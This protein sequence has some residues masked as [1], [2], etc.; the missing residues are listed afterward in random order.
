[1]ATT[2]QTT[3][4]PTWHGEVK[5]YF[6]AFD[7]AKM[8]SI[9]GFDLSSYSFV[10][11]HAPDIYQRVSLPPDADGRMPM[12]PG[13]PWSQD[14]INGF[15]AWMT[16]G[17]PEGEPQHPA[18]FK[19]AKAQVT[20][21]VRKSLTELGTDE[22]AKLKAAFAGIM[23]LGTEDLN[24][25]F[26]NAAIHGLPLAFC[27]HHDPG[28]QPWHRVQMWAFENC[29][30]SIKGCEDVTLPYWDFS[31]LLP[32]WMYEAPFDSYTL[33]VDIG[34]ASGSPNPDY[35]KG[36]QTTRNSAQVILDNFNNDVLK[37]YAN[38]QSEKWWDNFNGLLDGTPNLD[39]IQGHDAGHDATGD[40]M[41][42][43][44]ISAFDP[45][46]WFYHCN[47]DRM[48][49][50]WQA[51]NDAQTVDGFMKTIKNKSSSSYLVFTNPAVGTMNPWAQTL[52]RADLTAEFTIDL[53]TNFDVSYNSMTLALPQPLANKHLSLG[54][55]RTFAADD[56]E[57]DVRVADLNR[58][59]IPGTF[60]VHLLKDGE[61]LGT[62]VFFQPDEV[63]K[64][65][66]CMQ[67][68]TVHFDFRLPLAAVKGGELSI[69]VE[70]KKKEMY[71]DTVPLKV[72][73][74]PTITV[75][76]LMDAS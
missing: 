56:E 4:A 53:A 6:T 49:W 29:L 67:I 20:G 23:N 75:S 54:I 24:G 66:N 62:S 76:L 14:M 64:C 27:Q 45:I 40:T 12:D 48:W 71:G 72:L 16:A 32:D 18:A 31:E 26:Q 17:Y 39:F 46:F 57:V 34:T 63:E 41:S 58:T 44:N 74:T 38:A 36:Y 30:R 47:L 7:I 55:A 60:K 70:P 9:R 5:N 33:P 10:V 65:A 73:G 52:K 1:M 2:K 19:M 25:Y 43:Q 42:Q 68:P 51:N 3:L 69:R 11:S 50:I 13:T 8:R 59:K 22:L 35:K 61:V 28:F 15:L 37:S 21:R